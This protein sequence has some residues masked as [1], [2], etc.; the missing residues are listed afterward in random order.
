[1]MSTK[2]IT[3]SAT[4]LLIAM[5][6]LT[7]CSKLGEQTTTADTNAPTSQPTN[8]EA[9]RGHPA[10]SPT[11][12]PPGP[13]TQSGAAIAMADSDI[14]GLRIEV[15][16]LKRTSGETVTLKMAVV[17]DSASALGFT[18]NF[19]E[20]GQ[21]N[22]DYGSI[23]GTNLID[24]DNKKKYYVVRDSEGY[25]LCSRN[26]PE[27]ISKSRANLWAKFPAPPESVQ[28]I[29]VVISHFTPMDDVP[30]SR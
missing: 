10:S 13:A 29:T 30:I 27:V 15:Q 6:A 25:C 9:S 14:S 11:A 1:M 23:G 26:V 3:K 8:P 21:G 5:V 19:G 7:G 17:N 22:V 28:E 24:A 12:S 4:M 2:T 20:A 18:S 16:E